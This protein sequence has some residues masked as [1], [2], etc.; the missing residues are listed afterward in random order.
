MGD[1]IRSKTPKQKLR[2]NICKEC[3]DDF[4]AGNCSVKLCP[5]CRKNRVRHI[6]Q[7]AAHKRSLPY[8]LKTDM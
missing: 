7:R 5:T 8:Y 1:I 2:L 6:E 3:G 4:E